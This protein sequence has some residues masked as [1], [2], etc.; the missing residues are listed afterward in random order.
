MHHV[1]IDTN[2]L[3]NNTFDSMHMKI[4]KRLIDN[5]LLKLYI[6]DIVKKEYLTQELDNFKSKLNTKNINDVNKFFV[7]NNAIKDELQEVINSIKKNQTNIEDSIN[8]EF[9]AWINDYKIE[10]L[11]FDNSK[12][13]EV[14]DNYFTGNQVF[15]NIK[16]REDIPDS[17]ICTI[18]EEF[19]SQDKEVIFLSNDNNFRK[20][21]DKKDNIKTFNSSYALIE[22]EQIQKELATLNKLIGNYNF[23]SSYLCSDDFQVNLLN[24]LINN[25][26]NLEDV[27]AEDIDNTSI[28]GDVYYCNINGINTSTIEDLRIKNVEL[29]DDNEYALYVNFYADATLMY[30]MEYYNYMQLEKNSNRNLN[31][32]N[33]KGDGGCSIA[34]DRY[35][36]FDGVLSIFIKDIKSDNTD[37]LINYDDIEFE[38]HNASI[39][40]IKN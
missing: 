14:M 13:T 38:V 29:I 12:M 27:Y 2:I 5:D 9:E 8:S 11:E 1:V 32:E 20:Y 18:I 39:Q 3:S 21:L 30:G 37:D 17:M 25:Q 36:E 28:L 26:N 15:K 35:L 23:L 6:P 4:L 10:I 19:A 31:L 24:Y 33:M 22:T 16:N 34:E 40:E 7:Y